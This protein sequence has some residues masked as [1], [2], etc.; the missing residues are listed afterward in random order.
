MEE[1]DWDSIRHFAPG[2]FKHPELM[3]YEFMLWL[4]RV[5]I[6]AHDLA[7]RTMKF[8][9][10]ISSSYRD[11]AYNKK[12]GGA[13]NS[14]HTDLICDCVDIQPVYDVYPDD[15]NWNK[16]RLKIEKAAMMLGCVRIGSYPNSGAIHLDRT[17]DRRPMGKWIRVSGH[18]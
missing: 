5:W 9:M 7:P 10:I 15:M 3:G 8:Q 13:K 18:P 17:E 6:K 2:E 14:A 11:P 4:D 1:Q 16:H 12:V